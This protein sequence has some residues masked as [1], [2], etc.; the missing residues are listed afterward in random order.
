MRL[1]PRLRPRL[2]PRL[3]R[4]A[5][6][7]LL[8]LVLGIGLLLPTPATSP[9]ADAGTVPRFK[10][11]TLNLHNSLGPA[12]IRHD[13][14]RIAGTGASVIGL[15]ERRDTKRMIR[16]ALPAGWRLY[17]PTTSPGTDDNPIIW[18][19][20]VWELKRAWPRLLAQRTWPRAGHMAITQYAVV[21]VLEHR[22]TGHTIRA[23]SFHM[24]NRLQTRSGGPNWGE[25]MR[26]AAFWR[27][28]DNLTNLAQGTPETD[29]FVALC[30]CNVSWG[31]DWSRYLVKGNLTKRLGL[32]N[33]YTVGG[34]KSGWQID[35]VMAKKDRAF[36]M[37]DWRVVHDLHTDHPGVVA[38][39]RQAS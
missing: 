26:L 30:D 23:A 16:R 36:Q 33:N 3:R 13:I 20:R 1:H 5:L 4:H 12:G 37:L 22:R 7:A 32:E 15:Q 8:A 21:T 18:N 14:R 24:P 2:G 11:A 10:L 35:Y 29:Q 6:P 39:F 25:K 9:T 34:K 27:M 31:R 28:A 38:L 17:M 19:D